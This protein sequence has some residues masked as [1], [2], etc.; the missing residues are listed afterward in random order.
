MQ[1]YRL[2]FVAILLIVQ[3]T[4]YSQLLLSSEEYD[5]LPK[6]ETKGKP[7]VLASTPRVG[8]SLPHRLVTKMGWGAARPGLPPTPPWGC[9]TTMTG[10]TTGRT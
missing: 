4:C 9:C 10:N 1:F 3:Q 8:F 6:I 5:A 2:L 7:G